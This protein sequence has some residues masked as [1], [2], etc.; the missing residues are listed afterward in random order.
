MALVV[1]LLLMAVL[2]VGIVGIGLSIYYVRARHPELLTPGKPLKP[3]PPAK[4]DALA[5]VVEQLQ[6]L[7]TLR[8]KGILTSKEFAAKKSQLLERI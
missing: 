3:A 4:K 6:E 8:D 7:A 1:G 2:G 5:V